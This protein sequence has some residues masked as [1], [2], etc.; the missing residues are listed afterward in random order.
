MS[1]VELKERLISQIQKTENS[2]VLNEIS[3]LLN[4]HL[5]DKKILNLQLAKK[6][7]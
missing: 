5:E 7:N 3:K 6:R 2:N 1:T 4:F